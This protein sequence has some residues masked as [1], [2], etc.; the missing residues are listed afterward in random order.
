MIVPYNIQDLTQDLLLSGFTFP[1]MFGIE[2]VMLEA[3]T[4]NIHNNPGVRFSGATSSQWYEVS[5]FV[6][7][8]TNDKLNEVQSYNSNNPYIVGFDIN[9]EVYSNYLGNT[10]NGVTQVSDNTNPIVYSIDVNDDIFIGT[11]GQTTGLR[12]KT[13]SDQFYEL[14]DFENNIE[15]VPKT[16]FRF[17]GEGWNQTNS[18]LKAYIRKDYMMGIVFPPEIESD[19]FIERDS[20]SV[21]DNHL[22]LGEIKDLNGLINYGNGFFKLQ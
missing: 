14:R 4:I 11:D 6:T 15:L 21:F 19:L 7:G 9:T 20:I 8:F 17:V 22:R 13:Y 1:F 3:N 10:I 12:Y 16:E 18:E 5:G 2:P